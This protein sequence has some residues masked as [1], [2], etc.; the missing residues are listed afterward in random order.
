MNVL[1]LVF[2][3]SVGSTSVSGIEICIGVGSKKSI[4]KLSFGASWPD[5]GVIIAL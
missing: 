4:V 5:D 3:A 1:A 2:E